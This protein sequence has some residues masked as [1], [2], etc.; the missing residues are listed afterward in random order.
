MCVRH[1]VT[2]SNTLGIAKGERV[3]TKRGSEERGNELR[4]V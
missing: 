2:H 1:V 4:I 3:V